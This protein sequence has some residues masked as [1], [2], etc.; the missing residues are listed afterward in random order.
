[1]QKTPQAVL[2]P[3]FDIQRAVLKCRIGEGLKAF[4]RKFR[5]CV[6]RCAF[7]RGEIVGLGE[8]SELVL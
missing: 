1:M 6:S 4:Y 7:L 5:L 2:G 3:I 8:I